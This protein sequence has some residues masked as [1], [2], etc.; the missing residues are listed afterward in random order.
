MPD[1]F[2]ERLDA[3]LP[4]VA[5]DAT[6]QAEA[7]RSGRLGPADLA[8]AALSRLDRMNPLVNAVSFDG[9]ETI[10]G[11]LARLPGSGVFEGVPV[12]IKDLMAWPGQRLGLGSRLLGD[13]RPDMGSP[14][15]EA[16]VR[17]GLV[18]IGKSTTSEFGLLGTTETLAQGPTRN[19]ADPALSTGG[20]SGGAVAAVAAGIVPFAHA[21]DGGG[22]IRGPASLCGLFGFKP[23]RG[24]TL[25]AGLPEGAP[26][27]AL[28]S[29]HCVSRTVRDSATWL[30]IT[31]RPGLDAPL[32]G[33]RTLRNDPPPRLTIGYHLQDCWGEMPEPDMAAALDR[34]VRLLQG[35]GHRL[36]AVD[37]PRFD[38]P[39]A[40]AAVFDVMALSTAGMVAMMAPG[41]PEH[42][43]GDLLEPYTLHLIRHA[44]TLAPNRLP[45]ALG[46]ME[47]AGRRSLLA[48]EGLDILLS[49]TIPFLAFPLGTYGPDAPPARLRRH[50]ER[51]AA[52]TAP[53][54]LA[55]QP[56]M[57]V[58]LYRNASGLPAGSHF[59]ARPGQDAA[60]FRLAFQLE[61]AAPWDE[62][63]MRQIGRLAWS[64]S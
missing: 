32:P 44:A 4:L 30:S 56:A 40:A 2:F 60:L 8:R 22:S 36:V 26:L 17:A 51:S 59:S 64:R 37:G 62:G 29:E 20:S 27:S 33:W 47:E 21:S 43:M 63:I 1:G 53:A 13:Y 24:R 11:A 5:M 46:A 42:A 9:R 25:A 15:A 38:A 7:V 61:S 57:S 45:Q 19:P 16:L 6:A 18:V 3:D 31:E 52:Y 41:L 12:L 23:S 55:G 48:L 28:L 49:P 50:F 34:T 39:G 10:A 14:Y 35:L 58:P 54:S